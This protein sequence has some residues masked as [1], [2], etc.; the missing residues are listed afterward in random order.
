MKLIYPLEKK[1]NSYQQ[2]KM[3]SFGYRRGDNR[4][5]AGVDLYGNAGQTVYA[6]ADSVITRISDF[7]EGTYAVETKLVDDP[8][9][10]RYC[11]VQKPALEVGE[12]LR[13]GDMFAKIGELTPQS[14]LHL[15]FYGG[16]AEGKLTQRE[17]PPFK[18]RED[19]MNPAFMLELADFV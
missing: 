5:H 9:V 11:E 17:K 16:W 8:M 1:V 10:I 12:S 6:M 13:A 19:L 14:M 15:E 7:Y 18:R 4:K 3:G 2:G